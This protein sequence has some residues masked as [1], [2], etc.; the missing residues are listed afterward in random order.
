MILCLVVVVKLSTTGATA[1]SSRGASC[2]K[3]SKGVFRTQP[4]IQDVAFAEKV[5]GSKYFCEKAK[6]LTGV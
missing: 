1:G 5:H 3:P 2:T 4:Y 6:C